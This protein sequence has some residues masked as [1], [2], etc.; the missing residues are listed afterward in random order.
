[1]KVHVR[2]VADLDGEPLEAAAFTSSMLAGAW[3]DQRLE[4][5]PEAHALEWVLEVDRELGSA[6]LHAGGDR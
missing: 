2:V 6:E 3:T 1:M 4:E 5:Y